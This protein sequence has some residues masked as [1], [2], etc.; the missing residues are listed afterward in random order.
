MQ[1]AM[2]E[3]QQGQQQGQQQG[4]AR[5]QQRSDGLTPQQREQQQAI[6]A[7]MRRVPD[8]PGDLLRSKFQLENQRRKREGR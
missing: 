1:D 6:D 7:W 2:Q 4:D 3:P 5:A 8:E